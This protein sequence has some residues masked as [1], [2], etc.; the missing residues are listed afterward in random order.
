MAWAWLLTRVTLTHCQ[1]SL[2]SV[3]T[4]HCHSDWQLQHL[5]TTQHPQLFRCK[6]RVREFDH[7]DLASWMFHYSSMTLLHFIKI[8]LLQFLMET[9]AYLKI[10][11]LSEVYALRR[12]MMIQI[13]SEAFCIL[14]SVR[15]KKI[16]I[17]IVYTVK[18]HEVRIVC[19][20]VLNDFL[21]RLLKDP[22]L[23]SS[24]SFKIC[25]ISFYCD[26]WS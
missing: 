10:S 12:F 7:M 20:K 13:D 3:S 22:N 16:Q 6:E 14:F 1:E 19:N 15:Y 11:I 9:W 21:E 26:R 23:I 17:S 18:L 2:V 25:C 8:K 24:L 5:V 4:L